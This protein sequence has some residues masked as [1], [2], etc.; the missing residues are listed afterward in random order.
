M[1]IPFIPILLGGGALLA[2]ALGVKKGVDGVSY[3]KAAK[4]I[5]ERAQRNHKAAVSR[6]EAK[7][8][9]VNNYADRYAQ[10]LLDV[11]R[12]TFKRFVE[13][14][15]SLGQRGSVQAS[16]ALEEVHITP[17]QLREFKVAAIEAHHA[18]AGAASVAASSAGT[19]AGTAGLISLFGT[20]STGTAISGLSGAAATNATLAW[21]GGGS[22]AAGGGGMALG[23]VILGGIAIA[24]ALLVG[25]FM[26]GGRG[27]DALTE[28]RRY[29]SGVS[30]AVAKVNGLTC[31]MDRV[32]T[33]IC[34]LKTLVRDLD[35][36]AN[37]A[38]NNL[39]AAT[40]DIRNDSDVRNFQQAGIIVKALAEIM[41]TPVLDDQGQ[42]TGQS[43]YIQLKYRTLAG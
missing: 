17:P 28:A 22:L 16:Q 40:F 32:I 33:R 18:V 38:L 9:E 3:I 2:S 26:L 14:V 4:R 34:E 41:K 35:G 13:F 42:L 6:L 21:L 24:P 11:R 8:L 19:Y 23:T 12:K 7:R 30:I 29:E 1:P 43:R 36:K 31:F 25:G 5:S 20:A 10:H 39:D 15:E 27:Q 37:R